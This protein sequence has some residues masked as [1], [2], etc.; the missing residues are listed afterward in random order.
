MLTRTILQIDAGMSPPTVLR[1]I[2][3]LHRVPGVLLAEV[4]AANTRAVVAHDAA[5]SVTSLLAAVDASGAHATVVAGPLDPARASGGSGPRH[6]RIRRL[7]AVATA[8]FV[9]LALIDAL[10]PNTAN[11]AWLLPVFISALWLFF[12]AELFAGRRP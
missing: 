11:K 7:M 4:N 8:V 5:V 6:M 3:A 9:P 12:F 10:L 2:A 1:T